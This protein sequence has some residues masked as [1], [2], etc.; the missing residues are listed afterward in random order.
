MIWVIIVVIVVIFAFRIGS[1]SGQ[2]ISSSANAGGMSVKYAKL[3]EHILNG[4]PES[5]IVVE[6][7]TYIRAGVSNYG[8]T[9]MFHIQQNIGGTVLIDYEVKHNPVMSDFTLHFSFPD[10][11]DQDE[12]Y[13]RIG[14]GIQNKMSQL[15]N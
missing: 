11:M 14:L 12:M 5:K 6:T 7:R 13:E 15:F 2:I 4:H 3:R 1:K 10:T 8:G 9:T